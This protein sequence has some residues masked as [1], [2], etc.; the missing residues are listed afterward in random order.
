MNQR[1]AIVE[2][3]MLMPLGR[4]RVANDVARVRMPNAS[5]PGAAERA[6]IGHLV[7]R[8]LCGR[9]RQA[10]DEGEGGTG[11]DGELMN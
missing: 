11:C 2:K 7:G 3:R 8:A 10:G 5:D 1:S 4:I 9:T 6:E